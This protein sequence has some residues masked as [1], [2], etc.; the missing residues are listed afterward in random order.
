MEAHVEALVGTYLTRGGKVFIS[1]QF[2]VA[3]DR[4]RA[5]GGTCPDFVALDFDKRH[6]VIVEVTTASDIGTVLGRITKRQQH[7]YDPVQRRL[8]SAGAITSEW[9]IR[10]LCLLRRERV[11]DAQ[12]RLSDSDVTFHPLEDALMEYA[13]SFDRAKGLP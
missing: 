5:D 6:V 8:T 12:R 13:Y 10:T 2:T 11:G 4:D 3:W 7:W 1:P 9:K